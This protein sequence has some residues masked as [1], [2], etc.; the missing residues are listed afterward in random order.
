MITL[1]FEAHKNGSYEVYSCERYTVNVERCHSENDVELERPETAPMRSV[2]RMFRTLS[3]D[4]KNP[5]GETVG[6]REP[7]V[8]AYAMNDAGKTIDTI[9]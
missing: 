7:Y 5:Y 2:V 8:V 4:E 3:N 1:R 9:R 6:D